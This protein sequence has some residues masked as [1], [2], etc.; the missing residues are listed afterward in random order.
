MI[1]TYTYD[2]TAADGAEELETVITGTQSRNRKVLWAAAELDDDVTLVGYFDQDKVLQAGLGVD[3]FGA[4]FVVI[5][6]MLRPG[7]TF[8]VGLDNDSGG[9]V[10][11]QV[12]VAVEEQE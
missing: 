5:D 11:L 4:K 12:T 2:I 8:K 3:V 10:T 1:R 6:R 9:S 7:E